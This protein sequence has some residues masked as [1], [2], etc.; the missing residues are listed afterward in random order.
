MACSSKFVHATISFVPDVYS[1]PGKLDS[2]MAEQL[3]AALELRARDPQQQAM[4]AAYLDDIVLPEG[5]RILEIGSGSGPISRALATRPGVVEVVGVDPSPVFVARARELTASV[6]NVSFQQ[7]DGRDLP[8]PDTCF[9]AVVMHTLISH[10]ADPE[11]VLL[12]ALRVLRPGGWL[13]VFDG[14]YNTI[15]VA[16][17]EA[18]PLQACVMAWVG[19]FVNDPWVMRRLP[20]LVTVS[21]FADVRL[22]SHGYAE[23]FEPSYLLTIVDRGVDSLVAQGRVGAPLAEALKAEARRRVEARTFFGYIAYASVTARRPA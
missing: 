16:T 1:E 7:A 20:A 10:A 5:A 9:D 19:S 17:G 11:R 15:S 3:V 23:V 22:R 13:A 4:L 6:P 21:G 2:A 18:D 8:M 12:E 14:D